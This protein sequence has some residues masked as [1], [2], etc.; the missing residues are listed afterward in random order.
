M[1]RRASCHVD[2][3]RRPW[4]VFASV[5]CWGATLAALLAGSR[6]GTH[7]PWLALSIPALLLTWW[8][9]RLLHREIFPGPGIN[10]GLVA[11][12]EGR[13]FW[14]IRRG[15]DILIYPDPATVQQAAN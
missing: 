3:V 4:L 12:A 11:S 7:G 13:S 14:L 9:V 1:T 8:S 15:K 6:S 10:G 5:V 2:S